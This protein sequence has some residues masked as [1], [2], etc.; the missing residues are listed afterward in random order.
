[1]LSDPP[2][3]QRLKLSDPISSVKYLDPHVNLPLQ[4]RPTGLYLEDYQ[5]RYTS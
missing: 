5:K 4:N 1:M 3:D 2:L